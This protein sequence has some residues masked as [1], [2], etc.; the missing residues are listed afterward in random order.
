MKIIVRFLAFVGALVA[1]YIL[2]LLMMAAL[3]TLPAMCV[4]GQELTDCR[5]HPARFD[6]ACVDLDLTPLIRKLAP[7]P[8]LGA[9]TCGISTV[10]YRFVGPAGR[11]L[12]YAGDTYEI[13]GD[14]DLELI[15]EKRRGTFTVDGRTLPLDVW[16]KNAFGFREVPV[17]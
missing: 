4:Q 3:M 17:K 12:R 14:G 2:P 1:C 5:D 11:K 16:P 10:G 7:R 8:K 15:A 6:A 13:E 9:I